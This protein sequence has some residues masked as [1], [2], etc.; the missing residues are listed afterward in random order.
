MVFKSRNVY[1]AR[2]L[3]DGFSFSFGELDA[4]LKDCIRS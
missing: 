1:P 4:A 3:K 2:L